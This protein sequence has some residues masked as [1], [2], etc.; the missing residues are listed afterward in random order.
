MNI[1][2]F[3]TLV[4]AATALAGLLATIVIPVAIYWGTKK[5]AKL[6][7]DKSIRDFWMTIDSLALQNP[8][9]LEIADRLMDPASTDTPLAERQKKW[10]AYMVLNV[11]ACC[12]FAA[13][14]DLTESRGAT[15][16]C[17]E[18]L[19][20]PLVLDESV[21][22]LTQGFGNEPEFSAFCRAVRDRCVA[23]KPA[24]ERPLAA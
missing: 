18:D 13:K 19:A 7:Y 10:F 4:Q 15:L 20:T 1:Q 23:A 12:Y 2:D 3:A 5:I 6:Q 11:V 8:A 21:F 22:R 9:L 16:R 24:G 14:H 17:A